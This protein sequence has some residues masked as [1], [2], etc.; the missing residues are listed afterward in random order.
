MGLKKI[1]TECSGLD[2]GDFLILLNRLKR[3]KEYKFL[4]FIAIG[5]YCGLRAS[6][7]LKLHWVDIVDKTEIEINEKK[8][9]KHRLITINQNLVEIIQLCYDNLKSN[10]EHNLFINRFAFCNRAGDQLSIQYI[11]RKLHFIFQKYKIKVQN[12]SSHTLRKTFGKRC[13][14]MY[15]KSPDSVVLLS[16][17]FSHSSI[18]IT[19]AY[20][21]ISQEQIQNVYTA[22]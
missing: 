13:Y 17:I 6:D 3:D 12:G 10:G 14:E 9:G 2:W 15:D 21:G 22:L 18:A 20:I 7:I 1:K 11:N 5:S 16:Q 4:L 8:T 19:R